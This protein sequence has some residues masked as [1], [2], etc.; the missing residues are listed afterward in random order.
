MGDVLLFLVIVLLVYCIFRI[1]RLSRSIQGSQTERAGEPPQ[2]PLPA[3]PPAPP[4]LASPPPLAA[5]LPVV[6]PAIGAET[7]AAISA[8]ISA[9]MDEPHTIAG[10]TPAANP[11]DGY[12]V[13]AV[14]AVAALPERRRPVWGFAGMQQN[15]RPF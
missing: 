11:A 1:S 8:A 15:T 7:I 14:A 2:R 9:V 4:V 5:A 10:I 6:S 13:A 3:A 12:T